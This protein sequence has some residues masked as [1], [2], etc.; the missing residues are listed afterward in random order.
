[1]ADFLVL[2]L[3]TCPIDDAATFID[4]DDISVP[5]NYTNPVTIADFIVKKKAERL[6]RAALDIDL[7]RISVF[8]WQLI[9]AGD[10]CKI[11]IETHRDDIWEFNQLGRI[12]DYLDA[13]VTLVTFNGLKFD[14]P[15]LMRR[16][17]YLDVDFPRIN[18][19]RYRTPHIDLWDHLTCRGAVSAHSLTWYAKRFGWT[20]LVKPLS[21]AE[22]AMAVSRGQWD[23]LEASVRHDVMAVERLARTLHLIPQ[24]IEEAV[25]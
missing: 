6:E 7:A 22:E 4:S 16:A 12:A 13:G 2:D 5:S 3:A 21:A 17:L 23:E 14:W 1:M 18:C 24:H 20:D 10:P 11:V 19:D 25:L 9:S 8:G 15:L